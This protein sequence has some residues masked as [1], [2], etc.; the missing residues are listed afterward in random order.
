SYVIGQKA[1]GYHD[2][3]DFPLVPADPSVRNVEI[4]QPETPQHDRSSKAS[5]TSGTKK[6]S[7]TSKKF[8]SDD[9]TENDDEVAEEKEEE[10][11]EEEDEEDGSTEDPDDD[12]G[13][14]KPKKFVKKSH[15]YEQL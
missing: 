3:P 5:A 9:E 8:Y 13:E 15:D 2:L 1:T 6:K 7:S 12:E 4:I 10:E 14:A 11:E